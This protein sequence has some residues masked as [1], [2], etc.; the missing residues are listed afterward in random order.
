MEIIIQNTC[1]IRS[2]LVQN[3]TD[4]Q[5]LYLTGRGQNN[6]PGFEEDC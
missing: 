2:S 6:L 3:Y 4:S 1:S 5:Y